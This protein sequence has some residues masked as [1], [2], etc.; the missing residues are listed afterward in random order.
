MNTN[1]LSV[2]TIYQEIAQ[3]IAKGIDS[4][5]H[6]GELIK[7]A[8]DEQGE[9]SKSIAEAIQ[10]PVRVIGQL[11][12]IGR[13]LIRPDLLL[14]CYPAASALMRLPYSLQTSAIED[15]VDLLVDESD[16]LK[17]KAENLTSCQVKQVFDGS[18]VRSLAAQKAYIE[19]L[20][21]KVSINSIP[22]VSA[23]YQIKG[24]KVLISSA[25][26]LTQKD[27]LRMLNELSH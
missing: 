12:K 7:S 23:P 27:L 2:S 6:A 17:V 25:C 10:I 8:I 21:I 20:R 16:S 18:S 13:K 1:T 4:W 24:N 15:G 14:A 19:D 22:E 9:T 3:A 11:E 26:S 5:I